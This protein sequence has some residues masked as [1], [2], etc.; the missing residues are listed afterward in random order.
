MKT[1]MHTLLPFFVPYRLAWGFLGLVLFFQTPPLSSQTPSAEDPLEGLRVK[2]VLAIE[3]VG[4]FGR[5]PVFTDA[6]ESKLVEG[7]FRPP[8]EGEK[9]ELENG[10]TRR[11]TRV[12]PN[13]RGA[14][15]GP[16]FRGGYAYALVDSPRKQIVLLRATGHRHV[17]VNGEPRGG[18]VYG[19]GI[20][21]APIQLREGAN[22]L[23]FRTGRGRLTLQLVPPIRDYS[24]RSQDLTLPDLILG[25]TTRSLAG[26]LVVNGTNAW[27]KELSIRTIGLPG[28]PVVTRLPPLAPLSQRKVPVHL[29][30]TDLSAPGRIPVTFELLD[31]KG[32]VVHDFEATVWARLATEK[33]K[34]T[35]QSDLDGS[36]QYYAVTPPKS[37]RDDEGLKRETGPALPALFLSL[38]GAGVEATGQANSYAPKNWGYVV[39]PTNRRPFGF[40]WEDWGRLD[41]LE[42]LDLAETLFGTDPARTYL[43]GHSMGG[44]GTWVLGTQFPDRFAAIAPSAGWRDFWSYTGRESVEDPSPLRALVERAANPSRPLLARENLLHGGVYVLHGDRDDNVPVSQARFMRQQLG[45]FHPNWAYYERPGAGHWWGSACMD[46]PPLF[47]FLKRNRRPEDHEVL[48]F[49]FQTANPGVSAHCHWITVESQLRSLAMSRVDAKLDP[50]NSSLELRTENLARV[51]A[52]LSSLLEP[53]TVTRKGETV[54]VSTLS[55]SY[56]LAVK[57]DDQELDPVSL[58][59]LEAPVSFERNLEGT[60]ERAE[61]LDPSHKGPHRAGPFKD[62]FRHR[63]IFVYG[64][65]GSD[66]ENLWSFAKARYDAETFWYRGNGSVEILPDVEFRASDYPDRGVILYGNS[67]LNRAWSELLSKAPLQ[68]SRKEISVGDRTF[69]S[70]DLACLFVYP[71]KDSDRACVGVVAG[72]GLPGLRLTHQIP[73]FVSGVAFPDWTVLSSELLERGWEGVIAAG[74]FDRAWSLEEGESH[75]SEE[76]AQ[77]SR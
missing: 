75:V 31:Q 13:R 10:E 56:S 18:D 46:W 17:Y 4:R 26:V 37:D 74:F 70:D 11:W 27:A 44:H 40:D 12:T 54:E 29:A 38:H 28:D 77:T 71:R 32:S 73:Y 68:V 43:T 55:R 45:E 19:F 62:A 1:S 34:R 9:I 61:S 58:S 30:P 48:N 69:E 20:T 50:E 2:S 35:F 21:E 14:Y 5:T 3:P 6:L 42:V 52:N 23:L 7:T 57:I 72:T 16:A 53:R 60:W 59:T 36:V 15:E 67:D 33:H 64:T 49:S 65:Q 41:A 47:D 24:L 51:T 25:E 66:E 39:A 8:A 76:P 22:H 63:M